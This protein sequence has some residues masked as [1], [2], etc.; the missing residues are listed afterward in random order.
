MPGMAKAS[1]QQR[2]IGLRIMEKLGP[3]EKLAAPFLRSST[4]HPRPTLQNLGDNGLDSARCPFPPF[5]FAFVTGCHPDILFGASTTP[6]P[7][8]R[9]A[10]Q[11]RLG[12]C[13]RLT[14][15]RRAF[16]SNSSN[17]DGT[18]FFRFRKPI[19]PHEHWRVS[20]HREPRHKTRTRPKKT[21]TGANLKNAN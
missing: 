14:P 11:A 6:P 13:G 17:R 7:P 4:P 21:R 5:S 10:I 12:Q 9:S 15:W 20:A 2:M 16:F 19:T 18:R 8:R 3:P 1:D